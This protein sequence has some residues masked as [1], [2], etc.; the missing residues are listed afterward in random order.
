MLLVP[1]AL[2]KPFPKSCSIIGK[3]AWFP[4]FSSFYLSF[5]FHLSSSS[6]AIPVLLE[7]LELVFSQ[8][9][10]AWV[11]NVQWQGQKKKEDIFCLWKSL[12]WQCMALW[13]DT[14]SIIAH[15]IRMNTLSI[16][17]M[18]CCF[19]L[20]LCIGKEHII[21]VIMLPT[22]GYSM[23]KY[24]VSRSIILDLIWN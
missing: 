23:M 12:L 15:V 19:R 14:I 17:T 10:S 4:W 6:Q 20:I 9:F 1:S 21:N 7:P 18:L 8:F 3:K 24:I 13:F 16:V 22:V 11:E 5:Y 2:S